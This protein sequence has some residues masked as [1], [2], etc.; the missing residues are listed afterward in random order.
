VRWALVL[1]GWSVFVGCG[2]I[3][4]EEYA[5]TYDAS[6]DASTRD[7]AVATP[8]ARAPDA[9]SRAD[10]AEPDAGDFDAGPPCDEIPCQL[11]LPQCGCAGDLVCQRP[12]GD[13]ARRECVAP[14]TRTLGETCGTNVDCA[15]G[16]V[17]VAG[18]GTV[19][20]CELYCASS[21]GCRE[22]TYCRELVVM[23]ED[24]GSC[25]TQ[26]DP[27]ANTGCPGMLGCSL[28]IARTVPERE[29]IDTPYCTAGGPAI[30]EPCPSFLCAGGG[31]CID[32]TC[33]RVCD[34]A[35]PACPATT[36]CR[37]F[38]SPAIIGGREV[39]FCG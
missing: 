19:G 29:F 9:P 33:R 5:L 8:D 3:G 31:T 25:A 1:G 17:C 24:I 39:G 37:S 16:L 28:G 11:V 32:G 22:T 38:A 35:S 30:G 14:G 21:D 7:A 27:V 2:R 12:F 34:V 36:A 26:C 20:I 4:F 15:A 23:T 6:L 13:D 10:A 18:G